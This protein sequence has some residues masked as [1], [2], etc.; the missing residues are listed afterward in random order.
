MGRPPIGKTAMSAAERQRRHRAGMVA[1]PTVTKPS[2]DVTK[3][4]PAEV[5]PSMVEIE[6]LKA[7]IAA[8]KAEL[9]DTVSQLG[10][11]R[12]QSRPAKPKAER[13]PLPP[14]EVRDRRIKSL[15][16]ANRKLR[17]RIH[18]DEQY[19][20]EAAKRGTMSFE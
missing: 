17:A 4:K 6:S 18:E 3:P 11:Q 1:K 10:G 12:H 14:D 16:T 7:E 2:P 15:E 19:Y 13:S 20:A 8:L 5:D 9:A